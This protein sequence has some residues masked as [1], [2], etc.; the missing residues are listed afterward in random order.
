MWVK[1][2]LNCELGLPCLL[3]D[4]SAALETVHPLSPTKP[5]PKAPQVPT[6]AEDPTNPHTQINHRFEWEASILMT[7][8]RQPIHRA[9]SAFC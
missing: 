2:D 8:L 3:F 4:D 6:G 5:H 9:L 1:C 7:L